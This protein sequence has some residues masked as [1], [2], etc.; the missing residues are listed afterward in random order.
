VVLDNF[1]E[2]T[3]S[4]WGD[5]PHEVGD[6]IEVKVRFEWSKCNDERHVYSPQVSFPCTMAVAGIETVSM[7]L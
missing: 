4:F 7:S 1:D 5:F 3:M 6:G 2:M